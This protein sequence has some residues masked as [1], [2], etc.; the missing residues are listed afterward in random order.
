MVNSSS[1]LSFSIDSSMLKRLLPN[2]QNEQSS[3]F[4]KIQNISIALI[5]I[6]SSIVQSM[7]PNSALS[8]NGAA[9]DMSSFYSITP[10]VPLISFIKTPVAWR[11]IVI[12]VAPSVLL[13]AIVIFVV[14]CL[15]RRHKKNT[16]FVQQVTLG[17]DGL[18]KV[19]EAQRKDVDSKKKSSKEI[20]EKESVFPSFEDLTSQKSIW[21]TQTSES[22][23]SIKKHLRTT[24]KKH[25]N[26]RKERRNFSDESDSETEINEAEIKWIPSTEVIEDMSDACCTDSE[27]Y[28]LL[29]SSP[30]Q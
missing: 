21:S 3:K 23:V 8:A 14:I 5:Y 1:L 10:F 7:L 15:V 13:V 30:L 9:S 26:L 19:F 24:N 22:E 12:I 27:T 16:D 2:S 11:L 29:K 4:N 25:R 17:P 20:E 6:S 18:F 28:P